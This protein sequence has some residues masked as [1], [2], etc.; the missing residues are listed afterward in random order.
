MKTKMFTAAMLVFVLAFAAFGLVACNNNDGD[1]VT[2]NLRFA[3]PDGTPALAIARLFDDNKTIDGYN[4]NYSIVSSSLIVSEMAGEKADILIMPTN[5]GAMQIVKNNLNYKLV[6]VSVEG[7]LFV[8]GKGEGALTLEGLIASLKSGKTMASIGQNNT[9]DKVFR[10]VAGDEYANISENIEFVAD[11]PAA[12]AAFQRENNPVDYILVGEPAATAFTGALG[13]TQRLDLQ[14]AYSAKS[15]YTSFPQASLFVKS[16][17]AADTEFMNGLFAALE[18]SKTW[19]NVTEN[20]ANIT[21]LLALHDSA[22]TFPAGSISRCAVVVKKASDNKA[23]ITAYL[24]L[25][26]VKVTDNIYA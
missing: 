1:D 23:A 12:R 14:A 22:T 17:L 7:S 24:N 15:G 5:A 26:G 9:P 8:L 25:M 3:V 2:T 16:A 21:A 20:K 11:G 19:I 6:G 10:Y 4:M 13:M 18:D